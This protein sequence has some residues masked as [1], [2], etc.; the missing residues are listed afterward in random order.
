MYPKLH[1]KSRLSQKQTEK[2]WAPYKTA[3]SFPFFLLLY[4]PPRFF[5][6]L[7]VALYM[8]PRGPR[9]PRELVLKGAKERQ[10]LFDAKI[11]FP[12]LPLTL[13]FTFAVP[14]VGYRFTPQLPSS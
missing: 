4:K 14:S 11:P 8:G 5:K 13:I 7:G 6:S 9:T 3:L 12:S 2:D 10:A 1:A